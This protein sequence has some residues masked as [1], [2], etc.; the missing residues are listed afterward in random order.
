MARLYAFDR[1]RR[2]ARHAAH[3]D[4]RRHPERDA[5]AGPRP[6]RAAAGARRPRGAPGGAPGPV[7]GD[8]PPVRHLVLDLRRVP[9][10]DRGEDRHRGEGRLASRLPRPAGPV[11]VVRL[12]A[13]RRRQARR[14]RRDRER[15]PRRHGGGAG[16]GRGLLVLFRRQGEADP[17]QQVRLTGTMED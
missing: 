17:P 4:G 5:R 11:V 15:R 8:A 3:P 6:A 12:R 14:L 9:R 10:L 16:R 1:E 7:G 13:D 2:Q